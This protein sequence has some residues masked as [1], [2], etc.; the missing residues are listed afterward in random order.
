MKKKGIDET[1]I[2]NVV[3]RINN[4]E[5]V[6]DVARELNL[7]TTTLY[8]WRAQYSGMNE[9]QIKRMKDLEAENRMLRQQC[10]VLVQANSAQH[11]ETPE[12]SRKKAA[13]QPSTASNKNDTDQ[14]GRWHLSRESWILIAAALFLILVFVFVTARE[15]AEE[16]KSKVKLR[17]YEEVFTPEEA[18][19]MGIG[20]HIDGPG[21]WKPDP[22]AARNIREFLQKGGNADPAIDALQNSDFYDVIDQLG[23]EEGF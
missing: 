7:S 21:N 14:S 6:K 10:E 11:S 2:A 4:G 8:K 3:R 9:S 18:K 22:N 20:G 5:T 17:S 23:G 15:N 16:E 1:L 19:R 13:N 12:C